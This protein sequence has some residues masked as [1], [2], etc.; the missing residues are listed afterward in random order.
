MLRRAAAL[1]A[2][3]L[4][5]AAG[6]SAA[7]TTWDKN[8]GW[9]QEQI[10]ACAQRTGGFSCTYFPARALNQLFGIGEFC[11]AER[12]LRSHEIAAQIAKDAQWTVLGKASDQAILTQAHEMATGGLPVI[13]VQ[14]A[15]DK[16]MIAIVMPGKPVTSQSWGRK[17][18]LAVGTRLDKPEASVYS[19]GLSYLFSDPSRVTLYVQ[20]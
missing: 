13:A 20:K 15:T 19:Q 10:Q 11:D 8:A 7:G 12:C 2:A 18:P 17:V 3:V 16:G 6:A 1:C 9:L 5:P 14:T 4:I